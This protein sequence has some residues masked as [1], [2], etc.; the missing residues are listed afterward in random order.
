MICCE[1][2]ELNR[3]PELLPLTSAQDSRSADIAED[4]VRGTSQ[5]AALDART[6]LLKIYRAGGSIE[7]TGASAAVLHH[8]AE[9]CAVLTRLVALT[10][11]RAEFSFA[12]DV[13]VSAVPYLVSWSRVRFLAP[14]TCLLSLVPGFYVCRPR[15][16]I[17][18]RLCRGVQS[19]LCT[20]R[21]S[22]ALAT[23][24]CASDIAHSFA[25]APFPR[26]LLHSTSIRCA[27]L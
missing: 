8:G 22:F 27:S 1:F 26:V 16:M 14:P 5:F 9:A 3:E 6:A 12:V 19:E 20:T 4:G 10:M 11:V 21:S 23:A 7:P 15:S 13:R 2:D 24:R 25:L 17:E 18:L